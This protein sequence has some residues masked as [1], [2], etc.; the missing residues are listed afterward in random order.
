MEERCVGWGAVE[1]DGCIGWGGRVYR[2]G[3]CGEG[4]VYR[5]GGGMKGV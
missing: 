5:M 4:G 1:R 2:V 3:C